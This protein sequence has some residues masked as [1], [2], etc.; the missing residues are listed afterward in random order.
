M[1]VENVSYADAVYILKNNIVSKIQSFSQVSSNNIPHNSLSTQHNNVNS[2]V[3]TIPHFNL[4]SFP[5]LPSE[6]VGNSFNRKKNSHKKRQH[7]RSP[8]RSRLP[9]NIASLSSPNGAYLAYVES[10]RKLLPDQPSV[11]PTPAP[12]LS[13][14][15]STLSNHIS[16]AIASQQGSIS[17][18]LLMEIIESSLS[19]ILSVPAHQLE[20]SN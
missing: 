10:N 11:D 17:T 5:S 9:T 12:L 2:Q 1:A 15:V 8:L 14:V 16:A 13:D 4:S 18:A 3:N 19:N 6:N 7:S 20:R